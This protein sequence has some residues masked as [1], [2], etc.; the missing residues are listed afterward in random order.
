MLDLVIPPPYAIQ[1]N[2]N[3]EP[4]NE[5]MASS[6][7]SQDELRPQYRRQQSLLLEHKRGSRH[8][9]LNQDELQDNG[10]ANAAFD[11]AE[12]QAMYG[13]ANYQEQRFA[14]LINSRRS[15]WTNCHSSQQDN[16]SSSNEVRLRFK[17]AGGQRSFDREE[18]ASQYISM[19]LCST[20][21]GA[22]QSKDFKPSFGPIPA[23]R[24]LTPVPPTQ[25][26]SALVHGAQNFFS[27]SSISHGAN[28][29]NF[30]LD[31]IFSGSNVVPDKSSPPDEPEYLFADGSSKSLDKLARSAPIADANGN[32]EE[33]EEVQI[34]SET[35]YDSLPSEKDIAEECYVSSVMVVQHITNDIETNAPPSRKSSLEAT[36]PPSRKSSLEAT[37]PPSRISSLGT[38]LGVSDAPVSFE[39]T[40]SLTT[41]P[42]SMSHPI[43]VTS[44]QLSDLSPLQCKL[45]NSAPPVPIVASSNDKKFHRYM[46]DPSK[47]VSTRL[48]RHCYRNPSNSTS[49]CS[50]SSSFTSADS[51]SRASS[52][53]RANTVDVGEYHN[54]TPGLTS[55]A[56][57]K[58]DYYNIP[59]PEM[60][61][62][63]NTGRD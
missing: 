62:R 27:R 2:W 29:D 23:P 44:S 31:D 19:N 47:N 33:N 36:S 46:N 63:E 28:S 26:H 61:S 6:R 18:S 24:K 30:T 50:S 21:S 10:F 53:R 40:S 58:E 20:P 35:N 7:L 38:T 14:D 8:R 37:S 42:F 11:E 43:S 34:T 4:S 1:K 56:N 12:P 16:F 39:A 59:S 13:S 17:T 52:I 54:T 60:I 15:L 55:S 48:D 32:N 22:S 45:L 57:S 25:P 49:V 41:L 3:E 5:Y 9:H 51:R